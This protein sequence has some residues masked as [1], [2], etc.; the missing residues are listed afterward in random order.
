MKVNISNGVTIKELSELVNIDGGY[1]FK[2]DEFVPD[3]TPI[4]RI[5]NIVD[6]N[7]EIDYNIGYN[8]EGKNFDKYLINKN[9]ILIAMSGATTGKLAMYRNKD[10]ALLNQRVGRF[11]VL[12][13]N[14]LDNNYLYYYLRSDFV[15]G[16]IKIMASGCAQPNISP[17]Q[18]L[19]IHISVPLLETQKK[20]VEVLK[21]AERALEKRK[22]ANRLLD[23]YL[24]SIYNEKFANRVDLKE[25]K[26]EDLSMDKGMRT[27]PFGSD[28]KVGE[29]VDEGI[30]VLGIDNAVKNKFRWDELRY[31]TDEKYEK[32][33]RYT[34]YPEDVIITIMG[35]TGRVAV[36]P[37]D[38]PTA[39]STKH[40]ATI[41]F[42]KKLANPYF[43]AFALINDNKVKRQILKANKGAIMNGLN[44]TIIKGLKVNLPSLEEQTDFVEHINK[45]EG[46]TA[47]KEELENKMENLFNSLMQDAFNGNLKL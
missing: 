14:I 23:E 24:P 34:V 29:F 33:K 46:I 45:L 12:D 43:I 2:S 35:T 38:I 5:G 21:K 42:N 11:Y 16:K 4:I 31:I 1:A 40:L 36:V 47:K 18:L 30:A 13:S 6:G 26:I 20:I 27:G 3:K 10:T 7:V 39:I 44:L 32:L 28:L 37:K 19:S 22:E 41:T 15:Q 8:T 17:K 9:D 25:Y